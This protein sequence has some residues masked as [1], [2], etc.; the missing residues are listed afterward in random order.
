MQQNSWRSIWDCTSSFRCL[1]YLQVLFVLSYSATWSWFISFLVYSGQ[2]AVVKRAKHKTTGVEYAAKFIRKK[3][4]KASRRGVTVEVIQ[5]E[6]AV[7]LDIDHENIVKLHEVF[8]DKQDVIL[9][10]EL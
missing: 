8:E 7:L 3:R 6:V 9:I 5:R 1:Q 10:M 4:A 2:F